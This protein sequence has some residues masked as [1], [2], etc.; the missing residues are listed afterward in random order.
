MENICDQ[1]LNLQLKQLSE[2]I[3][4]IKKDTKSK[5]Y[6]VVF[7]KAEDMSTLCLDEITYKKLMKQRDTLNSISVYDLF[8]EKISSV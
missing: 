1:I 7:D 3:S 4:S 5:N 8:Q 6:I 2:C